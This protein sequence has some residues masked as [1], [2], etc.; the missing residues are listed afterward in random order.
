MGETSMWNDILS[1][2][3]NYWAD[4]IAIIL[5]TFWTLLKNPELSD[6]GFMNH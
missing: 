2:A 1:D 5:F 3:E 6:R 4:Y